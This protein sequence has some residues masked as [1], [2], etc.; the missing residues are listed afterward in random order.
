MPVL[1]PVAV[2]AYFPLCSLPLANRLLDNQ[3]PEEV[4]TVL[5]QQV[6]EPAEEL[7]LRATIPRLTSIEDEVSLLVQNQYEENPYPRWVK[8]APVREA[9]NIVGYLRQRFPLVSFSCH[10]KSGNIDILIAGCGTGQHSI[11]TAQQFQGRQVLAVDL[12]ISSLAYAKRKSR[13][14]GLTTIEYA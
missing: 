11:E 2:A 5:A 9:K 10:S 1:L 6:R 12:S 7:R 14:L 13:E 4:S 3:W 8:A